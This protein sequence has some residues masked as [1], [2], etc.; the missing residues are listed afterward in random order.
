MLNRD[1][2][3]KE[4]LSSDVPSEI[5]SPKMLTL[6]AGCRTRCNLRF[7][8]LFSLPGVLQVDMLQ[9]RQNQLQKSSASPRPLPIMPIY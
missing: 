9:G 1:F 3:D 8:N 5:V 6:C 2:Y 4:A 7:E